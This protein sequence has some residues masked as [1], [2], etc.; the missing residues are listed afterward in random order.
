MFG[1][2][3]EFHLFLISHKLYQYYLWSADID[4]DDVTVFRNDKLKLFM[5]DILSPGVLC[6][7]SFGR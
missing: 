7:R 2:T 3:F 4:D 1:A 5:S 6:I